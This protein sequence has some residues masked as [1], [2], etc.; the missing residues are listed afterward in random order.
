MN[1]TEEDRT[2]NWCHLFVEFSLITGSG[3]E[4]LVVQDNG[5][6]AVSTFGQN[7]RHTEVQEREGAFCSLKGEETNVVPVFY[8]LWFIGQHAPERVIHPNMSF[9]GS[10]LSKCSRK[11]TTL[12]CHVGLYL[13]LL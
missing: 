8:A 1:T 13:H 9:E 3:I 11:N 12:L 10:G 7:T 5:S 6:V 2:G 4:G